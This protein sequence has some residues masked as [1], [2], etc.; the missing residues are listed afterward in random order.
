M[1]LELPTLNIKSVALVISLEIKT[2]RSNSYLS[3][4]NDLTR[5]F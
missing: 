1:K 3:P 2:R 5:K 4:N